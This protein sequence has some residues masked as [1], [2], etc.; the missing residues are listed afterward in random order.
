NVKNYPPFLVGSNPRLLSYLFNPNSTLNVFSQQVEFKVDG[1][2]WLYL[3][4]IGM[5]ECEWNYGYCKALFF[6]LKSRKADA[7]DTDRAFFNDQ[8]SKL[9]GEFNYIFPAASFFLLPFANTGRINMALDKMSIN[10]A[11]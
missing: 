9:P 1:I 8:L 4:D 11:T 3:A 5:L 6:D 7:I 10:P 2:T